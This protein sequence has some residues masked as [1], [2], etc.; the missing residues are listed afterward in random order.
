MNK[1]RCYYIITT[2]Q[3]DYNLSGVATWA[4]QVPPVGEFHFG[5]IYGNAGAIPMPNLIAKFEETPTPDDETAY[6]DFA[7][8]AAMDERPDQ[9]PMAHEERRGRN[10]SSK[11]FLNLLHGGHRGAAEPPRHPEQ[12]F[13][14]GP[15]DRDPRGIA[16]EP[17][18][19][20]MARQTEARGRFTRFSKDDQKWITGGGRS[21]T[22][23]IEDNMQV[24]RETKK[25]FKQFSRSLDGRREGLHRAMDRAVARVSQVQAQA[26][27]GDAIRDW[28]LSPQRRAVIIADRILHDARLFDDPADADWAW[29]FGNQARRRVQKNTQ[30]VLREVSGDVQFADTDS[31]KCYRAAAILIKSL[32]GETVQDADYGESADTQARRVANAQ[33]DLM[34]ILVNLQQDAD[35]ATS[36]VGLAMKS[37][38]PA[39]Q[40]H[41][42]RLTKADGDVPAHMLLNAELI[43]RTLHGAAG[44][45]ARA[46]CIAHDGRPATLVDVATVTVKAAPRRVSNMRSD[47]KIDV[48]D[49]TRMTATFRGA[50]RRWISSRHAVAEPLV[51]GDQTQVGKTAERKVAK[52]ETAHHTNFGQNIAPVRHGGM[53]GSKR[54]R[55]DKFGDGWT[56]PADDLGLN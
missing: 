6:H 46:E 1:L 21:E 35:F 10:D 7:R 53:L 14:F 27:Y 51:D 50:R 16:D 15:E 9:T 24:R 3:M 22:K 23:A 11:G 19:A 41:L 44:G 4:P 52:R 30:T 43:R 47:A 34:A 5:G 26:A 31:A 48:E 32:A 55:G 42:A 20:L 45:V 8:V 2:T 37:A 29:H 56:P 39:V 33:R 54:A 40:A 28:A 17:N 25:R 36:D 13:G 12:Y 38:S 49:D 18:M